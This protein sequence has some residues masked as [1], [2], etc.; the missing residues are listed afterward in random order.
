VIAGGVVLYAVVE[1]VRR[2]SREA[3]VITST[4]VGLVAAI[5]GL[6]LLLL[7]ESGVD[8][9][10]PYQSMYMSVF[11]SQM[12]HGLPDWTYG[13]L[14]YSSKWLLGLLDG[15]PFAEPGGPPPGGAFRAVVG[16]GALALAIFLVALS[17][18]AI[19][20]CMFVAA[21]G[22][23][24]LYE[25]LNAERWDSAVIV[26]VVALVRA[27]RPRM[28]AT[29]DRDAVPDLDGALRSGSG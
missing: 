28:T 1:C 16:F 10:V 23:T 20:V 18:D 27:A 25:P 11:N 24:F 8:S 19:V 6:V 7:R 13:Y 15:N 29:G 21:L 9:R 12:Y 22:L 4:L 2:R 17:R 3:L 26:L 14:R 5:P